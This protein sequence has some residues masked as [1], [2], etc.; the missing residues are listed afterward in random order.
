MNMLDLIKDLDANKISFHGIK[1][2]Q[3]TKAVELSLKLYDLHYLA[4]AHEILR[5]HAQ[6][7]IAHGYTMEVYYAISF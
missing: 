4:R 1:V 6:D 7:F 5:T 3:D 2:N